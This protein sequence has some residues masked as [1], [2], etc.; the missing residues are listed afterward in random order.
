MIPHV[1]DEIKR[2][3]AEAAEEADL[4]IV[5]VG[6]TVGDIE[7][8]P[9]LEAIRQIKH[10]LG[11][12][13]VLFIHLTLVP[14]IQAA[15]ELK[16]K[17][18]QHS[19]KEL[20]EIGIQPDLLLCRSDRALPQDVKSKIGLFCNLPADLV[21]SA[22]DVQSIYEL[23]LYFHDEGLDERIV[24]R[25]GI[26]TSD[27][28]L[29]HWQAMVDTV[30]NPKDGEVKIGVVGKYTDWRDSYKSLAEALTHAGVAHNVR[31]TPQYIDSEELE[32]KE[33]QR[34]GRLGWNPCARRFWRAWD[35][36]K[37]TRY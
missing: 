33:P 18:T 28:S 20:R 30:K 17:P 14:F 11:G 1:T 16:T 37:N 3:I 31:V 6:G 23:P 10:E 22:V 13:N 15:G 26:W 7:S 4:C 9:F 12:E 24:E 2:L 36:R 32:K 8:L 21:F 5:E 19:V 27:G 25:L 35:R 29:N 34:P